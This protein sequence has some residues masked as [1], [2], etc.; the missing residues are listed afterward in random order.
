M[1]RNYINGTQ[2][3]IT[4]F[5]SSQDIDQAKV[6][7]CYKLEITA[8]LYC[9]NTWWRQSHLTLAVTCLTSSCQ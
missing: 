7:H 4:C 9:T 5:V 6:F 2:L 3:Q 1:K 8:I